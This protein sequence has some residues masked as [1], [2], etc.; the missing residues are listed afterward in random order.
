MVSVLI[1]ISLYVFSL[2]I[3]DKKGNLHFSSLFAFCFMPYS[4]IKAGLEFQKLNIFVNF[5]FKN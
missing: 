4:V 3:L 2:V 5:I 1:L